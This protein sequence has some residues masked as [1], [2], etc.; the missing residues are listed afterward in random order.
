MMDKAF[1]GIYIGYDLQS[2]SHKILNCATGKIIYSV[3]VKIEN[4]TDS[5]KIKLDEKKDS[6]STDK[7]EDVLEEILPL[8]EALPAPDPIKDNNLPASS[9]NP[10]IQTNENSSIE[11][12]INV[13]PKEKDTSIPKNIS[14]AFKCNEKNQWIKSTFREVDAMIKNNV[15]KIPV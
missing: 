12:L 11:N 2:E 13:A 6:I 14:H 8:S 15:W 1:E 10:V 3:N 7:I 9:E 4:K 5:R